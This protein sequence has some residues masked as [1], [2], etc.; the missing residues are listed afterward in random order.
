MSSRLR[1]YSGLSRLQSI[2]ERFEYLIMRGQVAHQTFGADRWLNQDFYQSHEWRQV[3][4]LVIVRDMGCDL[5]V[6]GYEIYEGLLV[7]HMNPIS[8]E[9]LVLGTPIILDPEYL[10]TTSKKTHN[11]IHY[12]DRTLLP[13]VPVERTFGDT[14]LW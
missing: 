5:G 2:E 1:T 4:E 3:R 9:D 6:A 11:A 10:I 13:S 14:R 12:G 7:H 8:A